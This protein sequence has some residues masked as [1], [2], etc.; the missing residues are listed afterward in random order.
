M[1][2]SSPRDQAALRWDAK[3]R[4]VRQPTLRE[5]LFRVRGPDALALRASHL[6]RVRRPVLPRG[7]FLHS[8]GFDSIV[9]A[10]AWA[11]RTRETLEKGR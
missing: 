6:A 11:R 3:G 9:L 5:L 4:A 2:D 7:R 1:S 8:R 10:E